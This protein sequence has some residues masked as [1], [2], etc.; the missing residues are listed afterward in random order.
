MTTDL[1]SQANDIFDNKQKKIV[2]CVYINMKRRVINDHGFIKNLHLSY[3]AG[4]T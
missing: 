1:H 3:C 2:A 4:M